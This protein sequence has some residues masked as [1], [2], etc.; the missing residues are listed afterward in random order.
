MGPDGV[1]DQF[2]TF[3]VGGAQRCRRSHLI[4]FSAEHVRSEPSC[5]IPLTVR[6][7]PPP[8]LTT[9]MRSAD[10]HQDLDLEF[11]CDLSSQVCRL[12]SSAGQASMTASSSPNGTVAKPIA[13]SPIPYGSTNVSPCTSAPH[14]YTTLGT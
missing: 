7:F 6:P 5:S 14:E 11:G 8:R 12:L 13:A 1:A 9:T 4:S 2:K 10:R 3:D